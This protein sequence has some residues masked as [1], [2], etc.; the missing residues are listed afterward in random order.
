M[1]HKNMLGTHKLESLTMAPIDLEENKNYIIVNW[2][3]NTH[4][5]STGGRC[6]TI[7]HHYGA[8]L[9]VGREYLWILASDN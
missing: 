7:L 2:N 4:I 1:S 5:T 9:E 3:S 8:E 6:F